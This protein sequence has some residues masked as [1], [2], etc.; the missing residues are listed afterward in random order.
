MDVAEIF[1]ENEV[2]NNMEEII[3][4]YVDEHDV[5]LIDVPLDWNEFIKDQISGEPKIANVVFVFGN[6]D[7][8]LFTCKDQYEWKPI[9]SIIDK[10]W[11]GTLDINK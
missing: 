1:R 3:H 2:K 5:L 6:G 4:Y 11:M 10:L 7:E 8:E 9:G